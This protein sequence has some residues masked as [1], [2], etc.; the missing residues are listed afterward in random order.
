MI[1]PKQINTADQH[2]DEW[3]SPP[4][5]TLRACA[6]R[7]I[8]EGSK[9][10]TTPQKALLLFK[11]QLAS[12]AKRRLSLAKPGAKKALKLYLRH[13][14]NLHITDTHFNRWAGLSTEDSCKPNLQKIA[15]DMR[16]RAISDDQLHQRQVK[17]KI[18]GVVEA[19]LGKK[20]KP[21]HFDNVFNK[22]IA[23]HTPKTHRGKI[24]SFL[25]IPYFRAKPKR[26]QT[27]MKKLEDKH[28]DKFQV[29]GK[30]LHKMFST[31]KA[32]LIAKRGSVLRRLRK[33]K[34]W[35][36]RKISE[37]LEELKYTGPR[38]VSTISRYETGARNI[39]RALAQKLGT[40]F[41]ISGVFFLDY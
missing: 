16:F 5:Q 41:K 17:A 15:L 2:I 4:S 7:L 35:Q 29:L 28:K 19:I 27:A 37:K 13:V 3:G 18:D 39:E 8:N 36:Q 34:N 1:L 38:S 20:D 11:K 23:K 10:E 30:E 25:A 21:R 26:L 24:Q 9:G 40:I 14:Q 12:N 22:L 33:T 32:H 31:R 6:L